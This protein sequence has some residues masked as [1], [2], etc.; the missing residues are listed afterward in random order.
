MSVLHLKRLR[1]LVLELGERPFKFDLDWTLE[2]LLALEL[3][4]VQPV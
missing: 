3:N 2:E 1:A 4:L